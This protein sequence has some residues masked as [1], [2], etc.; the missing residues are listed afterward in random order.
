M[1]RPASTARPAI[2]PAARSAAGASKP[3]LRKQGFGRIVLA[4][5]A[6]AP[7]PAT[8]TRLSGN[9]VFAGASLC[10]GLALLIGWRF[11]PANGNP[12]SLM[13]VAGLM[14]ACGGAGCGASELG[15]MSLFSSDADGD[16][17]GGG[18]GG[19]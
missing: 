3:T 9:L 7:A 2:A 15:L 18:D 17:G 19:D 5:K 13:L 1:K 4:P 8:A 11:G 14:A 12:A 6:D 10:F 16:A